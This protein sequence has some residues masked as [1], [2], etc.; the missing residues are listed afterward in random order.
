MVARLPE[1]LTLIA[2]K[3]SIIDEFIEPP[4][5]G[6]EGGLRGGGRWGGWR[7]RGE[8]VG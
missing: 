2:D 7:G 4:G 8:R 3:T 6:V 1:G 5:G